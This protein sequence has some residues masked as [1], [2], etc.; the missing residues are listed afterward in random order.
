MRCGEAKS[1]TALTT[2]H[3]AGGSETREEITVDGVRFIVRENP[4]S[5]NGTL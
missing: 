4:E 3:H 1:T 2:G 5:Y